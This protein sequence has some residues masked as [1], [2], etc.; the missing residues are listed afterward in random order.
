MIGSVSSGFRRRRRRNASSAKVAATARLAGSRQLHPA[1]PGDVRRVPARRKSIVCRS[2]PRDWVARPPKLSRT[3]ARSR[4]NSRLASGEAAA[5]RE[6]ARTLAGFASVTDSGAATSGAPRELSGRIVNPWSAA[7]V[8]SVAGAGLAV[9]SAAASEV[10]GPGFA[11][12]S[13]AGVA[14]DTEAV[15][16]GS[17]EPATPAAVARGAAATA[18]SPAGE[19]AGAPRG[20]SK[21]KG[22]T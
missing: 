1:D 20:G 17:A 14:A 8:G 10:F 19:G 2:D 4:C 13:T 16:A 3:E 11:A 15:T 21:V 12:A 9:E 5:A 6:R 18:G 22:S 7:I